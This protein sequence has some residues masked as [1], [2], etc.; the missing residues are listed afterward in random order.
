LKKIDLRGQKIGKLI[1]L[2]QSE[3]RGKHNEIY[4]HCK[5]DCGLEKDILS[6]SL[7]RKK[8]KCCGHCRGRSEKIIDLTGKVFGKL[9][10]LKEEGR[11]KHQQVTWLCRCE[12]GKETIV[13]SRDLISGKC[14]SCGCSRKYKF[15]EKGSG[16]RGGLTNTGKLVRNHIKKSTNWTQDVFANYDYTCSRCGKRGGRLHAHHLVKLSEIIIKKKIKSIEDI[17][18][19][20]DILFDL[21]NGVCL[22]VDCHKYVHSKMNTNKEYLIEYDCAS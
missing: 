5:C 9:F 3:K 4:W 11:T 12:C 13:S 6:S 17:Y 20:N 15:G 1:V 14:Q 22:C 8:I 21:E 16:W 7:L 19:N 18:S 10:V 2:Y